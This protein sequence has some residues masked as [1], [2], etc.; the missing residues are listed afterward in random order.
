MQCL[1]QTIPSENSK[2]LNYAIQDNIKE[3]ICP[4][5]RPWSGVYTYLHTKMN[6][7]RGHY[8]YDCVVGHES[9][10]PETLKI[11]MQFPNS[12]SNFGM[13]T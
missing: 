6:Y 3:L 1:C 11:S 4:F 5:I 2:C 13:K 9:E 10:N 7:L 12:K 8:K